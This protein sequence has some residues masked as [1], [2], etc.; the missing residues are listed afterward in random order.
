MARGW[1]SFAALPLLLAC[2][3]RTAVPQVGDGPAGDYGDAPDGKPIFPGANGETASFPTNSKDGARVLDVNKAW[4]GSAGTVERGANDPS[5]PDGRP[6]LEYDKDDGLDEMFIRQEHG[7]TQAE[8]ALDLATAEPN[9]AF[10]LNVLVD[11]DGDG[12]WGGAAAGGEEEWAIQNQA[13]RFEGKT[14]TRVELGPFAFANGGKVPARAWM[15]VALTDV[16]VPKGWDGSGQFAAGE[17]EDYLVELPDAPLVDVD[18]QNPDTGSGAWGF[19]GQRATRVTCRVTALNDRAKTTVPFVSLR[20]KGGVTQS[21]LCTGGAVDKASTDVEVS[22]ELQ[23]ERGRAELACLFVKE[24]GLPSV[25]TFEVPTGRSKSVLTAH[26]VE[27]GLVGGNSAT[28]TLE[29]G[30][31]QSTC[32]GARGCFGDRVCNDGCCVALWDDACES[33]DTADCGRCCAITAG[34]RAADCVRSACAK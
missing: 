13:V 23:L 16:M 10:F 22:G 3:S 31:C 33:L 24:W 7:K 11:L 5:D 2:S 19:G 20:N 29:K 30:D 34:A 21:G 6:N 9:G 25:F 15:R 32:R 4:M 26:G 28:F 14:R 8:L 17:I 12:S 1:L 27:A 18:C